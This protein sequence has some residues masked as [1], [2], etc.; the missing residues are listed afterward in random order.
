METSN[1]D[2]IRRSLSERLDNTKVMVFLMGTQSK[3]RDWIIWELEAAIKRD[4]PIIVVDVVR[5]GNDLNMNLLPKCLIPY[6]F[7][8]TFY[9]KDKIIAALRD[10]PDRHAKISLKHHWKY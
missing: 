2:T 9:E 1:D 4:I 10:W 7:G 3:F 5:A 8:H 6:K